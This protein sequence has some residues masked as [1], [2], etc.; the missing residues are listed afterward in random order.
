[1]L[2]GPTSPHHTP[3]HLQIQQLHDSCS[4][5]IRGLA[6]LQHPSCSPSTSLVNT[7]PDGRPLVGCH[8]GF[9]AGRVL[10]CCGAAGSTPYGPGSTSSSYQFSPVL[11]KLASDLIKAGGTAGGGTDSTLLSGVSLHREGLE[12]SS[13]SIEALDAWQGLGWLQQAAAVSDLQREEQQDL[14][15][16]AERDLMG[17]KQ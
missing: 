2:H 10:V 13:S 3:P 11:A 9:D 1:M 7:L 14:A 12:V 17:S 16:D 6:P 8:P 4:Q 15:R 5:L